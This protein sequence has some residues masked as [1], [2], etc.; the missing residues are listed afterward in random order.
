MLEI[1]FNDSA[2]GSMKCAKSTQEIRTNNDG[3]TSVWGDASLIP[4]YDNWISVPGTPDE[5][6]C[7]SYLLDVGD[8]QQEY[9][10][11]Y[12]QDLIYSMYTQSGW[13]DTPEFHAELKSA[14]QD[15]TNEYIRLMEL[16]KTEKSIRIWYSHT[17]H[18]LCGL[19]W[20]CHQLS[21]KDVDIHVVELPEYEL[22]SKNTITIFSDWGDVAA[23]KLSSFLSLEK[24]LSSGQRHMFANKWSELMEDNSPLRAIINGKIVGV[25]ENFYDFLIRKRITKTPIREA[26]LIGDILR[27]YPIG[28]SDWW[29][30][31]RIEKM[32]ETGEIKVIEDS[33]QKYTRTISLVV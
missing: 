22:T 16:L 2:A 17:P 1:L 6:I 31:A 8:I 4:K 19:Y 7:L 18:S 20:L 14:I 33:P 10:S 26:R 21:K 32:I 29:Y 12:R 9:N 23:E 11:S 30:G 15:S 28:V 27:L 25:P 3:P 5:V 24:K 13:D